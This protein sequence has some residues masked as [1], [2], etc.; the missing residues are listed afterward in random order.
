[1]TAAMRN[2]VPVLMDMRPAS[3][4]LG[5]SNVSVVLRLY[6]L[7]RWGDGKHC[8]CFF[9]ISVW[10]V[11]RKWNKCDG[12]SVVRKPPPPNINMT[13]RQWAKLTRNSSRALDE[14]AL[15][16]STSLTGTSAGR[17]SVSGAGKVGR[18][19]EVPSSRNAASAGF[20]RSVGRASLRRNKDSG[21]FLGRG[22]RR[23]GGG[24]L[25]GRAAK[26][27]G[28]HGIGVGKRL[29]FTHGTPGPARSPSSGSR[30]S[31]QLSTSAATFRA[32]LVTWSELRV[33]RSHSA[34]PPAPSRPTR[35][36]PGDFKVTVLALSP[37]LPGTGPARILFAASQL[38]RL[39][40]CPACPG[41]PPVTRSSESG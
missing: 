20:G 5:R 15:C 19:L 12:L 8:R 1:M 13:M 9:V 21:P 31:G 6:R 32:A 4:E 33:A 39:L 30:T 14:N 3:G 27:K 24:E 29:A 23:G 41:R 22:A 35:L 2:G 28:G 18:A 40:L 16:V 25:M 36:L 10:N 11:V 38:D 26:A 17:R 7:S 34:A 37:S